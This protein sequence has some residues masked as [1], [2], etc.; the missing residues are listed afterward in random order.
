MI[1]LCTPYSRLSLY[2]N[3]KTITIKTALFKKKNLVLKVFPLLKKCK[4]LTTAKKPIAID[5][6]LEGNKIEANNNKRAPSTNLILFWLL[7]ISI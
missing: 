2:S 1:S 4:Q 3:V 7:I 6:I 5:F